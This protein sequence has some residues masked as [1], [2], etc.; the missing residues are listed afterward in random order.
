MIDID[1]I[2]KLSVA[3]RVQLVE[4]I[5]DT[6]PASAED[7]PLAP[8]QKTE[9]DRRLALLQRDPQGRPWREVLDQLPPSE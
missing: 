1:E 9:L 7:Y 6:I 3:E 4:D 2:R 5:W 8:A